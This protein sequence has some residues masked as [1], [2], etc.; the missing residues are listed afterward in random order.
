MTRV[1]PPGFSNLFVLQKTDL[2]EVLKDYPDAKRILNARAKKLMKE[3]EERF[4]REK[5]DIQ[6][7]QLAMG[8]VADDVIFQ[9]NTPYRM[10]QQQKRDPALLEAVLK[11]LPE[12][13]QVYSPTM[14]TEARFSLDGTWMGDCSSVA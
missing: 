10:Q 7:R 11:I 1:F 3:N 9:L 4:L 13:S 5:R 6:M 12:H 14:I 2:E 8:S